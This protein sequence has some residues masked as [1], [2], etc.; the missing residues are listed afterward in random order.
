MVDIHNQI[1]TERE[2]ENPDLTKI[3]Q[4][5]EKRNKLNEQYSNLAE[6]IRQK[7]PYLAQVEYPQTVGL[8]QTQDLLDDQTVLLE[9]FIGEH[10]SLLFAI[11]KNK[12]DVYPLANEEQMTASIKEIRDLMQKPEPAWE[13]SDQSHT[14]YI[15]LSSSLYKI[16]LKPAEAMF[17]GKQRIVIAPDGPLYY[18]PFESLITVLPRNG[19]LDFSSFAY[20]AL[21]HEIQY[22]PSASVLAAFEEKQAIAEQSTR[23]KDLL[24]FADPALGSSATGQSQIRDWVGQL[25]SLPYARDE[26]SAIAGIYANNETSVLMGKQASEKNAKTLDLAGFR[27]IH[28]ASHG[29]IDEERPQFSALVL[30]ADSSDKEDGFLTMPEIFDL[31]LKADLVVLS[32]CKTGLGKRIRGEGVIGISRAFLCA[33]ASSVLVSLWNVY[34]RSSAEF[35]KSFYSAMEKDHKNK[36]DALREARLEMIRGKK[37]SHPY[38]WAPFVLIGNR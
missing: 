35:M 34:D 5:V 3:R 37:F 18:F 13:V 24:V 27:K 25:S 15:K 2:K 38:Y 28:F 11:T 14:K 30:S 16:L 8:T 10:G 31:K 1:E 7:N 26:A 4:L 29:L 9:Y 12:S 22:V 6:E 17:A 32:A 23:Q 36:A 19:N 20:L 33:G 21:R